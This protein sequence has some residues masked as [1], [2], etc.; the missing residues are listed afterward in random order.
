VEEK[1]DLIP[2][3]VWVEGKES[4]RIGIVVGVET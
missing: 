2:W 4:W 3:V 1:G